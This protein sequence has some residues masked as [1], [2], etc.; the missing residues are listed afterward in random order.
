MPRNHNISRKHHQRLAFLL[1]A[2]Y[3][4]ELTS[5]C[6]VTP[7]FENAYVG[8]KQASACV[9]IVKLL[10]RRAALSAPFFLY[11]EAILQAEAA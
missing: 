1:A 5:Q 3:V 6:E 9:G 11:H 8:A 2:V 10:A 4:R 7:C